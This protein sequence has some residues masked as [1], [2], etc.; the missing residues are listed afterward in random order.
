MRAPHKPAMASRAPC[1][2]SPVPGRL[3]PLRRQ[4]VGGVRE[5]ALPLSPARPGPSSRTRARQVAAP[6]GRVPG[7]GRPPRQARIWPLSLTSGRAAA[8]RPRNARLPGPASL[9]KASRETSPRRRRGTTRRPGPAARSQARAR[10]LAASLP[11]SGDGPRRAQPS[12]RPPQIQQR[13]G[14]A[15]PPALTRSARPGPDQTELTR[16]ARPGPPRL[17][18]AQLSPAQ[19]GP[20]RASLAGR[21]R[22][23]PGRLR[24]G[25]VG[26]G[27]AAIQP[28]RPVR[29]VRTSAPQDPARM[30]PQAR[31][32]ACSGR[33]HGWPGRVQPGR[34]WL[35]PAEPGPPAPDRTR[36]GRARA[37]PAGAGPPSRPLAWPAGMPTARA[38]PHWPVRARTDPASAGRACSSPGRSA[39]RRLTNWAWMDRAGPY[40]KPSGPVRLGLLGR[41][42]AR[43]SRGWPRTLL[44]GACRVPLSRGRSARRRLTNWAWM[45]RAGPYPKPSGPVRLGLLGRRP[46]RLSRGWPRTLL[47]GACRVPLSRGRSARRRPPLAWLTWT[48]MDQA[49]LGVISREPR[50]AL[51]SAGPAA[52]PGWARTGLAAAV[53]LPPCQ[54]TRGLML[55]GLLRPARRRPPLAWLTWTQMDQAALGLISREP[56]AALL[57]A[58]PAA[59]PGWARTGL[60]AAVPLPPCQLTRGLMPPGLL[61]P[62]RRRTTPA[63]AGRACSGRGPRRPAGPGPAWLMRACP[64]RV[65]RGPGRA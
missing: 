5:P 54:L 19:L 18:P 60:A 51:M 20:A 58:D 65:S 42:P 21:S 16:P 7:R 14:L 45:D 29:A 41:R 27:Q 64:S 12:S 63:A 57:S 59:W 62:A 22:A 15:R 33:C 13:A 47:A 34:T 28:V 3:T 52:W 36:L 55:P 9:T 35:V 11:P 50:A 31:A 49:A 17:S 24:P 32:V 43:L 46:A 39:R 6:S 38:A 26:R 25:P 8:V 1:P 4:A 2:A 40:P 37:G 53:P 23:R 48:Q 30:G 56:R 10:P 61:R 44:A